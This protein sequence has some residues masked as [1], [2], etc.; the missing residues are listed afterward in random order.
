MRF[1]SH[2]RLDIRY[3][4]TN[5]FTGKQV[6]KSAKAYL[7][8]P[9]AMK[10]A[11]AQKKLEKQGL[12]LK[13]Y[14]AYRPLGVQKIFWAIMPDERYVADPKKGSRHNRGSAVDVTLVEPGSGREL[15]MPSGYDDFSERAY[16]AWTNLPPAA[17]DI[18]D[19][20][21]PHTQLKHYHRN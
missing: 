2:I 12:S 11:E 5:N 19:A 7:H 1:N 6:Y 14:D 21:R 13:V 20:N 8:K 4:T 18:P 9:T 3:A 10:L 17:D 15:V 16:Y